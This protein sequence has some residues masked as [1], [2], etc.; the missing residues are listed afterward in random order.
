MRI[1]IDEQ[2]YDCRGWAAAHPGGR[3]L[4]A[5]RSPMHSIFTPL[6]SIFQYNLSGFWDQPTAA[7]EPRVPFYS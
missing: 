5:R 2:W 6:L 3:G 1:K 7:T 4:P